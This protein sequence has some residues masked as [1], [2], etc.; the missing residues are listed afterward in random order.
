M[1]PTDM[2]D[3]DEI[4]RVDADQVARLRIFMLGRGLASRIARYLGTRGDDR[5]AAAITDIVDWTRLL[6]QIGFPGDPLPAADV[7]GRISGRVTID[8]DWEGHEARAATDLTHDAIINARR[9]RSPERITAAFLFGPATLPDG[10]GRTP[11]TDVTLPDPLVARI[12]AIDAAIAGHSTVEVSFALRIGVILN[13]D[14]ALDALLSRL[15]DIESDDSPEVRLRYVHADVVPIASALQAAIR[16]RPLV[17]TYLIYL[18]IL[19]IID[20]WVSHETDIFAEGDDFDLAVEQAEHAMED[21]EASLRW[22]DRVEEWVTRLPD[23]SS[24]TD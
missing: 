22:L 17:P 15:E 20:T 4:R 7:V 24:P 1:R 16:W 8:E 5:R 14:Q 23:E 19:H 12:A 3:R 9:S 2:T 10:M 21:R 13:A 6:G 18:M 11:V